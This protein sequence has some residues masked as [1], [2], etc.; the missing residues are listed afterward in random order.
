MHWHDLYGSYCH[1]FQGSEV[2]DLPGHN[3]EDDDLLPAA[4]RSSVP[5][6]QLK[7]PGVQVLQP[8]QESSIN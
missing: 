4:I 1:G 7:L 6:K 3:K 2:C 5:G 8:E